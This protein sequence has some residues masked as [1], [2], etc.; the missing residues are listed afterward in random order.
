MI[1]ARHRLVRCKAFFEIPPTETDIRSTAGVP[2]QYMYVLVLEETNKFH[3]QQ[4]PD[5]S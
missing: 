3:Y 4:T 1:H 2:Y 5:F